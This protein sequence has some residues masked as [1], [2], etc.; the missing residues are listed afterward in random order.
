[1]LVA[2]KWRQLVPERSSLS[3]YRFTPTRG[4]QDNGAFFGKW[5]FSNALGEM[6][7]QRTERSAT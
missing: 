3:L 5:W 4:G 7:G 6:L 1:M 2:Q